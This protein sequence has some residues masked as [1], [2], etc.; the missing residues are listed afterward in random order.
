MIVAEAVFGE[1]SIDLVGEPQWIVA[2]IL[3]TGHSC[4]C[5]PCLVNV[6]PL[7]ELGIFN[8]VINTNAIAIFWTTI[9]F[10]NN[11]PPSPPAEQ[12]TPLAKLPPRS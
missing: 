5:A 12:T 1:R 11:L 7:D 3:G 9:A 6:G 8:F 4:I 10:L 2:G